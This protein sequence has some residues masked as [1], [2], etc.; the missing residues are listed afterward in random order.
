MTDQAQKA[1]YVVRYAKSFP[2]YEI[3]NSENL[4]HQLLAGRLMSLYTVEVGRSNRPE[5]IVFQ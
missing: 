3:E 4:K 5:P 1:H 2:T